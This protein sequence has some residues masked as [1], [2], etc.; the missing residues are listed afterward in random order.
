MHI[1]RLVRAARDRLFRGGGATPDPTTLDAKDFSLDGDDREEW[2]S[3]CAR[4]PIAVC[5]RRSG[6][7]SGSIR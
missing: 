2:N 3:A 4:C 7:T 5:R 1:P 6:S